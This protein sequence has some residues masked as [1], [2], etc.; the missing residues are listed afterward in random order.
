[1][2]PR[3]LR[4]NIDWVGAVDWDERLFDALIP[5][6]VGTSYNA[7]LIR[8]SEKTALIDTVEPKMAEVL[9]S[10]LAGVDHLD[11][12][13]LQ[14]AEQ[15]HSGSAHLVLEKYPEAKVVTNPRCKQM[16]TDLLPIPEDRFITV[17]DG[18]TLSLGDK[19]VQFIF[20]PWV[21]WPET[22]ATYLV[23]DQMLFTCD[24]Y[25]SHFATTQLFSSANEQIYE[26]ARRYYAEIMMP[27][28]HM[29]VR[30]LE[31]LKNYPVSMICPSHG[32]VHDRPEKITS[33]YWSWVTAAPEN[34][35]VLPFISMHG[36]TEKMVTYFT[37]ALVDQGVQVARFD[38]TSADTGKLAMELINA[39]T[40]VIGTPTVLGGA[41]PNAM[42]AAFLISALKPN[43]KHVSVIGSYGWGG[44]TV[45]QLTGTLSNL[46]LELLEPVMSKGHP[47]TEDHQN[48]VKLATAIAEKHKAF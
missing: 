7:Y 5:I 14:H 43:L 26:E 17:K 32:P 19:T 25:G 24:L 13:I 21:H 11:Y 28:R 27:L 33:L 37:D 48:L 30:D 4:N 47:L 8:G 39:P 9:F 16:L 20:V 10:R 6:P 18:D 40:L 38:L 15:D 36:S 42:S 23:E 35:V 45:E 46:N 34:K 1:M 44:R 2:K 41:H 22:M 29:V 3:Q 31:K 12:L